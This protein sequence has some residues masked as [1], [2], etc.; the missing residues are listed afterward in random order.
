MAKVYEMDGVIPVIDPTSFVHPDAVIIGDVI[1]GPRCYIG[2]CACLRGD[3][4]RIMIG[5]GSNIQDTCVIH[6]FPEVDVLLEENCHVGHGA[7]LH[8]CTIGRNALIG[9]NSVVMDRAVIGENSFVAAMSFV[10]SGMSAGANMLIAG[11]PA[12]EIRPLKEEEILWKSKGTMLYQRLAA[13][14]MVSMREVVPLASEEPDRRRV[15]YTKND[16][17]PLMAAVNNGHP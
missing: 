14:S 15:S 8:G 2:P 13:H 5:A 11:V 3:L 9:M 7:I 1:I 10:K 12:K 17:I 4:G 6:S 16:A